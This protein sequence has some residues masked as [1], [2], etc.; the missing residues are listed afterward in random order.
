MLTGARHQSEDH[1]PSGRPWVVGV[2]G[3]SRL[4]GIYRATYVDLSRTYAVASRLRQGLVLILEACRNA[5]TN[6]I[7]GDRDHD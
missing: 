6:L 4:V 7:P 1:A 2:G 5:P 3:V